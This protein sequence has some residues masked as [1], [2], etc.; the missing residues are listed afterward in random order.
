MDSYEQVLARL[1]WFV[2]ERR[3]TQA[4]LAAHLGRTPNY[5]SR[6]LLGRGKLTLKEFCEIADFLGVQ[7]NEIVK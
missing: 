7:L 6:A 1:K 4:E 5:V 3:K 2:R